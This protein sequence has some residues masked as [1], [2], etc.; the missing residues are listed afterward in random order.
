MPKKPTDYS[1]SLIYKLCSND[2]DI[3]DIYVG[4]T[5]SF[6][7]RKAS[8]KTCCNNEN[9]GNNKNNNANV[10]KFIRENGGWEAW[11]MILIEYYKCETK[12]E[13]EK[14]E[15]EIIENLKPTL[16][17]QIPLR[18]R[19]E[20]YNDNKEQISEKKREYYY[21]NKEQ[22]LEKNKEYQRKNKKYYE[23]NNKKYYENNKEQILEQKKE[24]YYDNKEKVKEYRE[25]NKEQIAEKKKE[26][27]EK[28]KE[29]IAEQ[30]KEY[31][32]KNKEKIA[33]KIKN[34]NKQ[35]ITCECGAIS[36]KCHIARHLKTK[37]HQNYINGLHS[38]HA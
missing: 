9:I 22:L 33:E 16:N 28:K 1:K 37:K 5:T 31:Y 8:H 29:Q 32:K 23:K 11:N 13:L 18:T 34:N 27:Y 36:T 26:Y 12:L 38:H 3:T 20:W 14:K 15:R 17:K 7:H 35:T 6:K 24:Y 19:K 30:K 10:Y 4:S 2:T 25:K 21:D